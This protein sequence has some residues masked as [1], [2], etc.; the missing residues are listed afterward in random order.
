MSAESTPRRVGPFELSDRLGVGGMGMVYRATY[1]KTGQQVALKMLAPDLIADPKVAQRFE[2]EMAILQKLKH[3]HIIR[4]YGGS[5]S[6]SQRWYAMEL[7]PSG[8]LDK[9]IREKGP[10][11]WEQTVEYGIQIAKALE[12]AHAAGVIHR[13]LKPANLLVA[14][15]GT[16]KLSDFGIARDTEATALTQAGKTVG[17]MAYMAPEQ[18]TGKHPISRKTDL[19][20]LGCVLFEMLAGKPPF[21][22]ETQ[23]EILFKHLDEDP[24]SVREVAWQTPVWLEELI[25]DLLE[26]SPDDRP[27]DALAVQVRLEEVKTKAAEQKSVVGATKAG[28]GVTIEGGALVTKSLSQ[29]K[30]KK[31][32]ATTPVWERAWFLALCLIVVVSGAAWAVWPASEAKLFAEAQS[33]VQSGNP[34]DLF[35]AESTLNRLKSRYPEGQ[36]AGQ[37]QQWLD[38]IGSIRA[39]RN[40][41]LR[42]NLGKDAETEAERLWL[43]ARNYERF[44]DRLTALDKYDAM[45]SILKNDEPARPF[46]NLA[47]RQAEKIRAELGGETD[48]VA[49]VNEKLRTADAAYRSG[50]ELKAQET[51]KSIVT[52]YGNI[53]EFRQQVEFAERRL[54]S[55]TS[56]FSRTQA[57]PE[58]ESTDSDP[59]D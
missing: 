47:R 58:P 15:N 51:W 2:R 36:H 53:P 54:A 28:G 42:L 25:H 59:V 32:T 5:T 29:K 39:E 26:K 7:V 50:E 38:D 13:D 17:T 44:G 23:P 34:D 9:L 6:G 43:A 49:F 22:A 16:L 19:Y 3:P 24:P 8:A 40:L 30:K 20:A 52:L 11:V 37:V 56:V 21:A 48:R 55:P 18:I 14:S 41:N 35:K 31:R 33:I 27:F 10:L 57:A 4:Y 45:Q 12:H 46:R 1:L